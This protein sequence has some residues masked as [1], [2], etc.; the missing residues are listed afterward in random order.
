MTATSRGMTVTNRPSI[1]AIIPFF[2]TQPLRLLLDTGS[3]SA[4]V[5]YRTGNGKEID[6]SI[7]ESKT[8]FSKRNGDGTCGRW[9]RK[10]RLGETVP[11]RTILIT[12]CAE[13]GN[14]AHDRDGILPT[15]I[16]KRVFISH[17]HGFVIFDPADSDAPH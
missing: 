2:G 7:P 16:F 5:P 8:L 13:T 3:E 15:F 9:K 12:F 1:Q 14:E 4:N 6:P 11:M 10:V 17:A